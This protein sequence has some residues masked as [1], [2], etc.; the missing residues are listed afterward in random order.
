MF[1]ESGYGY[2]SVYISVGSFLIYVKMFYVREVGAWQWD[3]L[4]YCIFKDIDGRAGYPEPKKNTSSKYTD[5]AA[6]TD[7]VNF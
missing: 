3:G 5:R 2:V 1:Y 6:S 7:F 4:F